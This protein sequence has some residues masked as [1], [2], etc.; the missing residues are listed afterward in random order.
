MK[1]SFLVDIVVTLH[2]TFQV[3]A[4]TRAEVERDAA[5]LVSTMDL[6]DFDVV[7]QEI[8]VYRTATELWG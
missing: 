8:S 2:N 1:T 5:E 7:D 3:E 4:E 6:G